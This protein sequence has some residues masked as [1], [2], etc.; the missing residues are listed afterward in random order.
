M[1]YNPHDYQ[2]FVT[3]FILENPIAAKIS[4]DRRGNA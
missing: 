1:K 4:N 3:K 2:R